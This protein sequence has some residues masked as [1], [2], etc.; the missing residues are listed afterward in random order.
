MR[1]GWPWR[2]ARN[3]IECS[4]YIYVRTIY[5]QNSMDVKQELEEI[6]EGLRSTDEDLEA[7]VELYVMNPGVALDPSSPVAGAVSAA[8]E[9]LTGVPPAH[10]YKHTGHDATHLERGG[11]TT[12]VYGPGGGLSKAVSGAGQK[13]S[14]SI[15]T[16][17][18]LLLPLASTQPRQQ[19][20]VGG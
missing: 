11:I 6:I 4:L 10:V 19:R 14:A 8:H 18:S 12:I 3:P 17:M 15:Y 5:D 2:A 7:E 1:G 9:M 16:W 13:I 20:F